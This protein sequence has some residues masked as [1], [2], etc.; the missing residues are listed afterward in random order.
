MYR[1]A[2]ERSDKTACGAAVGLALAKKC[3]KP[4]YLVLISH[5]VWEI[6][7]SPPIRKEIIATGG[8]G[9]N[10]DGVLRSLVES[11]L[12]NSRLCFLM[13]DHIVPISSSSSYREENYFRSFSYLVAQCTSQSPSC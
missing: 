12:F 4:R 11:P 10:I 6:S 3:A 7:V 1:K 13:V 2:R 5:R 9:L 8:V